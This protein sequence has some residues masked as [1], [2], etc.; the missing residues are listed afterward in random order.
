MKVTASATRID[1]QAVALSVIGI[2]EDGGSLAERLPVAV[3]V[4]RML[5]PLL[6]SVQ[7]RGKLKE[8]VVLPS[9]G[10]LRAR[11]VAVVGLG[12]R[13]DFILESAR[14]FG[15]IAHSAARGRKLAQLAVQLPAHDRWT[16]EQVAQAVTEGLLLG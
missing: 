1:R 10:K 6:E 8:A 4:K 13:K 9:Q 14:K 3:P 16:T 15:G 2:F 12:K 5:Q 7:F 11:W